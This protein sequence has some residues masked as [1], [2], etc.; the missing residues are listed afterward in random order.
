M[1]KATTK[2]ASEEE[3]A[4]VDEPISDTSETE[5]TK[6][7]NPVFKMPDLMAAIDGTS[8]MKRSELRE[9]AGLVLSAISDALNTGHTINLPGLGK[10]HPKRREEKENGDVLIARIKLAPAASEGAAEEAAETED[11]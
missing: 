6:E 3:N 11:A 5:D 10:I 1:A 8:E 4:A 9:A 7:E 2:T